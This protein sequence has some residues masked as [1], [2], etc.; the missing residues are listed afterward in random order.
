MCIAPKIDA[1]THFPDCSIKEAKS[2]KTMNV[3]KDVL[4]QLILDE[5]FATS[6][7]L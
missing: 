6:I 4:L 7:E 1:K 5:Q 2:N 3:P